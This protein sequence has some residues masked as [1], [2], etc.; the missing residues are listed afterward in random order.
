MVKICVVGSKVRSKLRPRGKPF[1]KGDRHSF[2][3]Q[4]GQSG[5]PGGKPKVHQTLSMNYEAQLRSFAPV[6]VCRA[7]DLPAKSTW[8]QVIAA[9]MV[10]RAM[11]DVSAAREIRE[12]TEGRVPAALNLEGKIDYSAGQ[13]AKQQLMKILGEPE[14]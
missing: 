4:P 9:G 7:M 12:V 10:R 11:T 6:K 13:T 3:F 1:K 5:N 14:R 2:Q 8:A